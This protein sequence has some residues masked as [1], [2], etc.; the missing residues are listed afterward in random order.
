VVGLPVR[1]RLVEA[2]LMLPVPALMGLALGRGGRWVVLAGLLEG[3][4][5]LLACLVAYT[6][7]A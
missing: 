4:A 2:L 7:T 6:L 3:A 5:M 1:P